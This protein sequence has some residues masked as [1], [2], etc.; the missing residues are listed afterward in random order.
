MPNLIDSFSVPKNLRPKVYVMHS[1]MPFARPD[2]SRTLM[3][4]M[5]RTIYRDTGEWARRIT[6]LDKEF[7]LEEFA[8]LQKVF[9]H[10]PDEDQ[11]YR[12]VKM[13]RK[14]F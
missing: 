7:K 5:N 12:I 10:L 8:E 4:M 3:R 11:F 1:P 14:D 6:P 2:S 13:K 9:K